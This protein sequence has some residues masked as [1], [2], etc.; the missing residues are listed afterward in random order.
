MNFLV[1]VKKKNNSKKQRKK[2]NEIGAQF[3]VTAK[4]VSS[5]AGKRFEKIFTA[6]FFV[7]TTNNH[8][9]ENKELNHT[10]CIH[11]EL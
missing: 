9:N 2:D 4:N 5:P 1:C 7:K 11:L 6:F 3:E 10:K 8:K